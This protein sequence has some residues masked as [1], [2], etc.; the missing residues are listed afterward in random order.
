MLKAKVVRVTLAKLLGSAAA[1]GFRGWLINIIITEL[2]DE[3]VEP[4]LNYAIRK[5]MLVADKLS[6]RV[7]VRKI[8]RA[9][10]NDKEDDYTTSISD[11]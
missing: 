2:F 3:V 7:T 9:K 4:I 1:K 5:G 8:K 10:E 6:G 11:V